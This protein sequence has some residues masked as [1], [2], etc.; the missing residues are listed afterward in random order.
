MKELDNCIVNSLEEK[1]K[2]I[3]EMFSFCN[4]LVS[5]LQGLP[6]KKARLAKLKISQLLFEIEFGV[7]Y[8][9]IYHFCFCIYS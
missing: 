5:V 6:I 3:C 7:E 4:S 9:D 1:N 8:K 2:T